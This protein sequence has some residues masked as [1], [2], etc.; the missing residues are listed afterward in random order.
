MAL[1]DFF[2]KFF[3]RGNRL[4]DN[5]ELFERLMKSGAIITES[6]EIA[7]FS[8]SK[9]DITENLDETNEYFIFSK[10]FGEAIIA[11]DFSKVEELLAD[12]ILLVLY[13]AKEITGKANVLKYWKSWLDRFNE[14]Y[15][16]TQY[17]I[18]KCEWFDRFV[19]AIYP[20]MKR[21][22]YLVARIEQ[23]K[24]L[25]LLSCPNPLQDPMIRYWDLDRPI[26]SFNNCGALFNN[27]GIDLDPQPSR[28]PC[29]RC[30]KKSEKLQW[31]EFTLERGPLVYKGELTICPECMDVVEYCPTIM[32]KIG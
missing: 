4:A 16:G 24:V 29:M 12:D 18:K 25:N 20:R 21:R 31:Y 3:G 30:G 8:P 7:G 19:L 26:L 27:L 13:G 23:G 32:S 22:M 10:L 6:E 11:R 14:P 28:M 17:E 5:E 9:L 15:A 1:K 2:Y